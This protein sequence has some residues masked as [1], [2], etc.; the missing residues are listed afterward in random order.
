M[1][2]GWIDANELLEGPM[3]S[4]SSTGR[5][6]APGVPTTF[7]PERYKATT[8]DQWEA[9][10]A[11]WYAWGPVIDTWLGEATE[12]MFDLAGITTGSKVLDVAA[13]AGGQS[14]AAARRVGPHGRVLATDISQHLLDY[15]DH[16]ARMAGLADVVASRVMDG[17]NLEVDAGHFDA[18]IS[19]VGLI[20][21]PDRDGAL[22]GMRR[23][24]RP[25]GRIAA[26]TYSTPEANGFFS[27][28]ISIIREEAQLPPP[29]PGQPGPF[30]LGTVDVLTEVLERAGFTD[31]AVRR[32][33]SPLRL[34]SAVDYALFARESFG[35]LHQMMAGLDAQAREEVWTR[36]TQEL[37]VFESADGFV[38]P[39]EMLVVGAVNPADLEGS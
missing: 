8:T 6:A 16:A 14:I 22:V 3:T 21:F 9:A 5:A 2:F 34:P 1:R 15:A 30:S 23:A 19:R 7:D 28:P 18:V 24:L 36:I 4:A 17:E 38:G 20:Y 33:P 13:G 31:V 10:A 11:A 26:V 27:L 35:A 25:G 29:V 39:C 12:V 32:V 37:S